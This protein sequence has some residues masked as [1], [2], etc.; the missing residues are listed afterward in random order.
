MQLWNVNEIHPPNPSQ[1]R[2]HH[3]DDRGSGQGPHDFVQVVGCQ[4]QIRIHRRAQLIAVEVNGIGQSRNMVVD[5]A[6]IDRGVFVKERIV[7]IGQDI[8]DIAFRGSNAAQ[9][10]E[11]LFQLQKV[12][13]KG[14][15]HDVSG[16]E[17]ILKFLDLI[18]Q[19]INDREVSIDNRI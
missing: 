10:Q 14:I 18:Y 8:E 16:E 19:L 11:L 4:G 6:K 9:G 7:T 2:V 17:M 5:I 1:Q 15:L 12:L 13:G 3:Q